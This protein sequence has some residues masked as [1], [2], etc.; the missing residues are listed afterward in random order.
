MVG[1]RERIE[2][3]CSGCSGERLR[4]QLSKVVESICHL[5][6]RVCNKASVAQPEVDICCA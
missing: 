5:K 3:S 1:G 2:R 4:A 6:W